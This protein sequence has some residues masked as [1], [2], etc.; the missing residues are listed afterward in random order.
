MDSLGAVGHSVVAEESIVEP[1]YSYP[2]SLLKNKKLNS[3]KALLT[4]MRNHNSQAPV[5]ADDCMSS[6]YT[7][8]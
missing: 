6:L 8:R 5:P 3:I 1:F 2:A 7:R 4:F